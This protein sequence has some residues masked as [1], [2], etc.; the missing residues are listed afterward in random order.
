MKANPSTSNPISSVLGSRQAANAP[1]PADASCAGSVG[2][3]EKKRT[4][5]I[6]NPSTSAA[7]SRNCTAR[8]TL[9]AA[10]I[11]PTPAPTI[12]PRLNA[13][14]SRGI[15]DR[16][17]RRSISA[18]STF[19]A[20]SQTPIPSP[21][22]TRPTAAGPT[23]PTCIPAANVTSP[24]V[25]VSDP[26]STVRAGPNRCTIGPDSGNPTIAPP[27]THSSS[28]PNCAD[29]IPRASRTPGARE[30]NEATVIPLIAKDAAT[31]LRALTTPFGVAERVRSGR[32]VRG[33]QALARR[34]GH[35]C[36]GWFPV[37]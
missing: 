29:E 5:R 36:L 17:S 9:A 34:A 19:I 30:S 33:R 18:P 32:R 2:T 20:T 22:S 7:T 15:S 3:L 23:T 31:A 6:T 10:E 14:C 1:E 12:V 37:P 28:S 8:G 16:P 26:V 13:A 35:L 4:A 11:T 25:T 24:V 21:T 27:D